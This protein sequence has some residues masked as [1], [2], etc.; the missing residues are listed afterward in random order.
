MTNI[1]IKAGERRSSHGERGLKY[2]IN[3]PQ[4]IELRSLLTRGAWIEIVYAL[5]AVDTSWSLLTRGAWIEIIDSIYDV[6]QFGVAPHTG[7]VD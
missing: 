5:F 3:F 2:L 4:R 1:P 6:F 7:S